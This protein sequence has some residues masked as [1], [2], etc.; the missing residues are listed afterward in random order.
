MDSDLYPSNIFFDPMQ[1]PQWQQIGQLRVL[2]GLINGN[3]LLKSF[4][5]SLNEEIVQDQ[6]FEENN[7]ILIGML[8]SLRTYGYTVVTPYSDKTFRVQNPLTRVDWIKKTVEDEEGSRIEKVGA[9]FVYTDDLGNSTTEDC[10]FQD[11]LN[12]DNEVTAAK[13]FFFVWK[14]GDNVEHAY[15]PIETKWCLGD[16]DLSILTT[17][18]AAQQIKSTLEVS[19][20]KPFFLHFKYGENASPE[21]QTKVKSQMGYVGP[22]AAF[23]AKTT[24]VEEIINIPCSDIP[25]SLLSLDKILQIFANITHLPLSYLMGERQ[26]GGLGDTGE[27]TDMVKLRERKTTILQHFNSVCTE[28]LTAFGFKL[29]LDIYAQQ[30][31][32]EKAEREALLGQSQDNQKGG[33]KPNEKNTNA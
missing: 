5:K 28:F 33:G 16:M 32:E 20:V 24:V 15:M 25:S 13:S 12:E 31:E 21:Q 30:A 23:G 19:A 22:N 27:S 10:Y 6:E 7:D 14:K 18:I 8:E 3:F 2:R 9:Q 4:I 17:A 29:N 26:A 1:L 11:Q